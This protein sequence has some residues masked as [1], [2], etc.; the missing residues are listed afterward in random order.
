MPVERSPAATVA[1]RTAQTGASRAMRVAQGP[2]L[3]EPLLRAC[4]HLLSQTDCTALSLLLCRLGC[5]L[6][7]E[8]GPEWRNG[9][10][11]RTHRHACVSTRAS[12]VCPSGRGDKCP[13]FRGGVLDGLVNNLSVQPSCHSRVRDG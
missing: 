3:C 5:L 8:D 11:W 6:T 12:V 1:C 4:P 9:S 2:R 10:R 7:A 13:G